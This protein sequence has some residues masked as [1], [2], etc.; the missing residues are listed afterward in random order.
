M[1]EKA[2]I[3]LKDSFVITR[4]TVFTL[5]WDFLDRHGNAFTIISGSISVFR[6]DGTAT[7]IVDK[8]VGLNTISP[9]KVQVLVT[10]DATETEALSDG[11]HHAR[12]DLV[13]GDSQTRS[14]RSAIRVRTV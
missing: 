8:T 13:F 11:P 14:G 12:L 2:D 6:D 10:L 7:A 9:T 1:A 3:L 4:G 5:S